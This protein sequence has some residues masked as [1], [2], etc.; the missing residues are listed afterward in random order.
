MCSVIPE[1]RV[2]REVSAWSRWLYNN[3]R[4]PGDYISGKR[5]N[6]TGTIQ[7]KFTVHSRM[8]ISTNPSSSENNS[9]SVTHH[10][11]S[12]SVIWCVVSYDRF[13]FQLIE[14]FSCLCTFFFRSSLVSICP[15][16]VLPLSHVPF[17]FSFVFYVFFAC[18]IS[19]FFFYF[20]SFLLSLCLHHFLSWAP[21]DKY[22]NL[23]KGQWQYLASQHEELLDPGKCGQC[24]IRDPW[25]REVRNRLK[26][27]S[28]IRSHVITEP[29]QRHWE[30]RKDTD[31]CDCKPTTIEGR[32]TTWPKELVR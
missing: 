21:G 11:S 5:N 7:A 18:I 26:A 14:L 16:H 1:P 31:R 32:R 8:K 25:R 15:L 13:W 23:V 27:T 4:L 20:A 6:I 28:R 10:C 3:C 24:D 12:F 19:S 30:H 9:Q 22:R 17:P 29:G 2:M